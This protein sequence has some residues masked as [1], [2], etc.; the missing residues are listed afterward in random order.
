LEDPDRDDSFCAVD[1]WFR[2]PTLEASKKPL[3]LVGPPGSGKTSL[4]FKYGLGLEQ[5]DEDL[6]DFIESYGLRKRPAGLIDNIES[7][8]RSERDILRSAVQ[9]PTRRL[10]LTSDDIYSEPA[11]SL[12]KYCTLVKLDRPKRSF[13]LKVLASIKNI[14]QKK[15]NDIIESCGPESINLSV[16][17]NALRWLTRSKADDCIDVHADMPMDVPKA[18]ASILFGKQVPCLGG[19]ADMSFLTMMLQLN[20]GQSSTTIKKL[21]TTLD[22]LSLLE[23]AETRYIMDTETHWN[24]ISA[25]GR[26]AP[27]VSS[28]S[29]FY[30]I[31]P[32]S[33][34]PEAPQEQPAKRSAKQ[35]PAKGS[36]TTQPNGPSE[37]ELLKKELER[38]F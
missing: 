13:A 5:Y 16:I 3:L 4:L 36:A 28:S 20:V 26:L 30:L 19:S 11:K 18:T 8:D 12:A 23:I 27:Q 37:L 17:T 38:C 2:K 9:K 24:Y 15:L 21:S 1:F 7:L 31:W 22:Q 29:R 14:G 10:V 25:I 6:E 35:R 32:K 33:S 34:K